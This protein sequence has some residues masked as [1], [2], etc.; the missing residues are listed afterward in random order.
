MASLITTSFGSWK[1]GEVKRFWITQS[2][3]LIRLF[4]L[5]NHEKIWTHFPINF[6]CFSDAAVSITVTSLTNFFS[7]ICGVITPFPC[8]RIFCLYTGISIAFIYIWHI[9]LFAGIMALAG[10]A[11]KD[12][13]HGLM[14][15]FKVTPKSLA[16]DKSWLYRSFMTGGINPSDPNNPMDNKDHVIMVLFR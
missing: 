6:R 5:S 2:S 14:A 8:V 13:R 1:N 16:Q 3:W 12:N 9:T 15:C 4:H 7:F 10:R 11:E